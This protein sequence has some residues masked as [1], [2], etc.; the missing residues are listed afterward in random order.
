MIGSGLRHQGKGGKGDRLEFG[1]EWERAEMSLSSPR[2]KNMTICSVDPHP[3]GKLDKEQHAVI[4]KKCAGV[5]GGWKTKKTK[6]YDEK[7]R[8]LT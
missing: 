8:K 3:A 4:K 2:I 6:S 1:P 5:S 7:K